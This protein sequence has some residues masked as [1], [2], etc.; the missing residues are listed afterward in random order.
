MRTSL[1]AT[2]LAS[3]V[4]LAYSSSIS[5]D[6]LLGRSMDNLEIND[7]VII[8]AFSDAGHESVLHPLQTWEN[9]DGVTYQ[10]LY[11][12]D[13]DEWKAMRSSLLEKSS[14]NEPDY[15]AVVR[16]Q[17][18]DAP[19]FFCKNQQTNPKGLP[20]NAIDRSSIS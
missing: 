15:A 9:E 16:R 12:F 8:K 7:D 6:F 1:I 20:S 13:A 10:T 14:F 5:A 18:E 2:A 19:V 3:A 17:A 11:D 4:P